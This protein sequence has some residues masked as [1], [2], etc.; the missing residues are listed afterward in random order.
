[1]DDAIDISKLKEL[2]IK[3][4][5]ILQ[6][7]GDY[8]LDAYLVKEGLLRSYTIDKKGKEHIF[9]FAPEGWAIA[10]AEPQINSNPTQL[11]IDSLEDSKILV[12]DKPKFDFEDLSIE[13]MKIQ[14]IK[15]M[16]R[17]LVLQNRVLKLMSAPAIERYHE[18]LTMYPGVINRVPQ[19]MIAS[20]LGVT[21]E[22]LS[23]AKKQYH[24]KTKS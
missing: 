10:D 20:Y 7:E 17:T 19:H 4:G 14:L 15:S 23:F 11:F 18:F 16:K 21:P 2:D 1:M 6:R 3:K 13:K 12:M 8:L 22:A 5:T 24:K 9:M